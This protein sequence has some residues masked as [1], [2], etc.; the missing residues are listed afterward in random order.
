MARPGLSRLGRLCQPHGIACGYVST[1]EVRMRLAGKV[2][3]VTGGAQGIGRAAVELFVREGARVTVADV[4]DASE[5]VDAANASK[6]DAVAW[7]VGEAVYRRTDVTD[8]EDF[9]ALLRETASG[10]T[11]STWCSTTP[12]SRCPARSRTP[13][14]RTSSG[15]W[16]STSGRSSSAAG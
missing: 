3:I 16:R 1:P 10:G 12:A 4:Q 13:R 9:A 5:T 15:S 14:S 2:A 8:E 11:A 6:A 7:P